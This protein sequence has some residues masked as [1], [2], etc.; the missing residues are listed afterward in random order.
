[1]LSIE[2]LKKLAN[3]FGPS[4][5]EM[6][7]RKIIQKE[8]KPY[9]DECRVNKLGNLIARKKGKGHKV[10]LAAHMDEVALMVK[11]IDDS[12]YI[13]ISPVGGIEP[14]TLIGQV[15]RILKPNGTVLCTG[16]IAYGEVL[17]GSEIK[18]LPKIDYFYVDTGLTKKELKN[19]GVGIGSYVVPTQ[20]FNT[21][22]NKD[23]ITGKALDDRIGCYMLVEVAK[24][25]KKTNLDIYFVFS[26]Q[27]EIGLYGAKTSVYE[28]NPN[29]G[30][31][32]DV[33]LALDSDLKGNSNIILGTGPFLTVKDSEIIASPVLDE[34]IKNIAK[35]YKIPLNLEIADFGTTDATNMMLHGGGVP[36]TILGVAIRNIHTT[37]GIASMK[38]I[39]NCIKLLKLILENPPKKI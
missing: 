36:S 21:L 31:A 35:K 2:L 39:R 8:I 19:K 12:G 17:E 26:V 14:V 1:M 16:V 9:V 10:M 3:T 22:G 13:R 11:K 30:I 24:L 29:W 18:E 28:V 27:E 37:A 33:T 6:S 25:I 34:H 38:D 15:A 32:V 23:I 5:N 4:G 20:Q 7:V